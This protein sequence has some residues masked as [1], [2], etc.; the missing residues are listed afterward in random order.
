[1]KHRRRKIFES[2]TKET[3]MRDKTLNANSLFPTE[4]IEA[5]IKPKRSMN[6][7]RHEHL[8]SHSFLTL[9][10]DP[11]ASL[12]HFILLEETDLLVVGKEDAPVLD[13]ESLLPFGKDLLREV[14]EQN[15]EV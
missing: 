3:R 6:S 14:E 11:L 15:R 13:E 9:C 4:L 5:A 12:G 1:M 7:R 10:W 8:A 2:G